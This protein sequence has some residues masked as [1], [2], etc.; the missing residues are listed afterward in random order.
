MVDLQT[1][2]QAAGVFRP[3]AG[4]G[5][6]YSRRAGSRIHAADRPG[7]ERGR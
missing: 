1:A 4:A 3:A 7:A 6:P 2:A 5:W